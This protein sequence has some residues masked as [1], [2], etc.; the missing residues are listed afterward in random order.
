MEQL[1]KF[2]AMASACGITVN[3]AA[4]SAERLAHAAKEAVT[5]EEMAALIQM[6]NSMTRL[7]K[8][9]LIRDLQKRA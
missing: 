6:N 9:R 4:S 8:R 7:Q 1:D 2:I 5:D 3:E